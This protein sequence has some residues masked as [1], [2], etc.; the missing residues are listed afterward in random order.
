MKRREFIKSG[1]AGLGLGATNQLLWGQDH[2]ENG[3]LNVKGAILNIHDPVIIKQDNSYY[4]FSTGVGIH[5]KRSTDLQDWRIARG[6]TVF[7]KMPEEASGYVP[8]ADSI[9][10]PDISYYNDRYHIYYS[11]STFGSNRSAIGLVTNKTLHKDDE[12]FE[13]I[14]HGIVIKSD[15]GDNFNAIDANLILDADDEPWLVFGSHW[16]GIKMIKLDYETGKQSTNDDTIYDIASRAVHPR[17]IEAP[18]IIYHDEYYYLFVSF[19]Q[20]CN[21]IS[22]TYNVR[23]GR[24]ETIT[25]PYVDRDGVDMMEDGGT[26]IL[27]KMGRYRGPGHNA[28]L[29]EDGQDYIVY[30]TYDAVQ[31][32]TPTLRIQK[33]DWDDG[34]CYVEG[35][36]ADT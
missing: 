1:L 25:G 16:S 29:R 30:H 26:Q 9:W 15:H 35:M 21:G 20:C 36:E 32:G 4:L 33:L 13:W 8:D 6:G 19:D 7:Q 24:S 2:S 5:V 3:D 23:V 31:G 28:I 14:D 11:V 18:F 34:W 10:A 17:A 22:S 27:Y 12:D